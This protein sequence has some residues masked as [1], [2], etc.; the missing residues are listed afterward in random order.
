ME[1]GSP[2]GKE[3]SKSSSRG[4]VIG[5]DDNSGEFLHILDSCERNTSEGDNIND[6]EEG[7]ED[8][9]LNET[10]PGQKD[11]C[12]SNTFPSAGKVLLSA[13]SD[14]DG[15]EEPETALQQMFSN[16]PMHSPCRSISL[17][18]PLKLVSA[19]KGSREKLGAAPMKLTVKWAPDVYD[20]PPT[21]VSHTVNRSKKQ[22][23]LKKE[24]RNSKQKSGKKWQKGN[25][26]RGSSGSK[27]K[28][29]RKMQVVLRRV[30]IHWMLMI[31]L[32]SP[33]TSMTLMLVARTPIVA[34]ASSNNHLPICIT[35]SQRHYELN[36]PFII[37]MP[38]F[39]TYIN[40]YLKFLCMRRFS[41]I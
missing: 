39:A 30:T 5:P 4:L 19:M 29:Y 6:V 38:F 36:L 21:I 32:N 23:K 25:S 20:P 14:E 3:K 33:M 31:G 16:E 9:K 10:K 22:Q 35:R 7:I 17:P 26:S 13:G 27:N 37:C 11:L 2:H 40:K 34:V 24:G 8:L 18:T 15:D 28:Q 1:F 41:T 12:K